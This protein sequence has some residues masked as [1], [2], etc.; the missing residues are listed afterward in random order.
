MF[1]QGSQIRR[2]TVPGLM[3]IHCCSTQY[4]LPVLTTN[5]HSL[6]STVF[7]VIADSGVSGSINPVLRLVRPDR[8]PT[9]RHRVSAGSHVG[10]YFLSI[11]PRAVLMAHQYICDWS[12]APKSNSQDREDSHHW[13]GNKEYYKAHCHEKQPTQINQ[14]PFVPYIAHYV[15][16]IWIGIVHIVILLNIL[17]EQ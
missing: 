12:M 10:T 16:V 3:T 17:R 7:F 15:L 9:S 4:L 8:S 1:G 13:V 6:P 11:P 5:C 14:T 2:K